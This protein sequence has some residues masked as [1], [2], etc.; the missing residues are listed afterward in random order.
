MIWD[1]PEPGVHEAFTTRT[2]D[3]VLEVFE[4]LVD[5][6]DDEVLWWAVSEGKVLFAGRARSVEEAKQEVE[7][8]AA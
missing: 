5:E 1:N 2:T 7:R 6:D 8:W 4:P 3:V